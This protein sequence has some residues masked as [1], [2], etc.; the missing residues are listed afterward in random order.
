MKQLLILLLVTFLFLFLVFIFLTAFISHGESPFWYDIW[1]VQERQPD[2]A[3]IL[4]L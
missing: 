3:S 4:S 1:L 2:A